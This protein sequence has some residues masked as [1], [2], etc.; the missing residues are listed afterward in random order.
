MYVR[1]LNEIS[2]TLAYNR[3]KV[4][5][6]A[7]QSAEKRA[8]SLYI[9]FHV[10]YYSVPRTGH[11]NKVSRGPTYLVKWKSSPSPPVGGKRQNSGRI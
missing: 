5:P 2:H 4:S 1:M 9:V 11:I 10:L 7:P 6:Y 8:G 3:K